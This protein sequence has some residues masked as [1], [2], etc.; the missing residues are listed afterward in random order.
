MDDKIV[1]RGDKKRWPRSDNGIHSSM[2]TRIVAVY[3]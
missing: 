3:I 1:Y 2:R